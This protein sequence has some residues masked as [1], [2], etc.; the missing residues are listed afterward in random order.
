MLTEKECDAIARAGRES[1]R[2]SWRKVVAPK[3]MAALLE[4]YGTPPHA[5]DIEA[6][7]TAV[8]VTD[9]LWEALNE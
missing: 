4:H 3:M 2:L 5:H 1:E 9:A 6:A 8:K 7:R